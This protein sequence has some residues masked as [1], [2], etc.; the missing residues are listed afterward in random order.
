MVMPDRNNSESEFDNF[1][2][3]DE[4]LL[5]IILRTKELR[6][7]L[8]TNDMDSPHRKDLAKRATMDRTSLP[9]PPP[10]PE[11]GPKTIQNLHRATTIDLPLTPSHSPT[12]PPPAQ[13]ADSDSESI[14]LPTKTPPTKR[15][16]KLQNFM[17]SVSLE[18]IKEKVQKRTSRFRNHFTFDHSADD[19]DKDGEKDRPISA[20]SE[21]DD[22]QWS[23]DSFD[24]DYGEDFE[25]EN[26]NAID[27]A[28]SADS[29]NGKSGE[30]DSVDVSLV[31]APKFGGFSSELE[32]K[33]EQNRKQSE[34]SSNGNDSLTSSPRHNRLPS[35][36][37]ENSFETAERKTEPDDEVKTVTKKG[38]V[39]LRPPGR[40]KAPS[41]PSKPKGHFQRLSALND[42]NKSPPLKSQ[43]SEEGNDNV[44]VTDF[45]KKIKSAKKVN[46]DN[47][48]LMPA[49]ILDKPKIS[50]KP[51][52]SA[53]RPISLLTKP[54]LPPKPKGKASEE[55]SHKPEN[56]V[57]KAKKQSKTSVSGVKP[58]VSPKRVQ[59]DPVG[60]VNI[61]KDIVDLDKV[62]PKPK[63][64]ATSPVRKMNFIS[65]RKGYEH[66][67]YVDLD[68][69]PSKEDMLNSMSDDH[70]YDE[71]YVSTQVPDRSSGDGAEMVD[72]PGHQEGKGVESNRKS[73]GYKPSAEKASPPRAFRKPLIEPND[74]S[75][76]DLYAKPMLLKKKSLSL[77]NQSHIKEDPKSPKE[78]TLKYS[79][80]SEVPLDLSQ[81]SVPDVI[82]CLSL[83][84]MS[85]HADDFQD[86]EID[87]TLL[88]DLDE[89]VLQSEF[90]FSQFDAKKLVKFTNGWRPKLK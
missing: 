75:I 63:P 55:A 87:G 89:A 20:T 49:L 34:S 68:E 23:D 27:I 85:K 70:A 72:V 37:S 43:P 52:V 53:S 2:T 3:K 28:A 18:K 84:K 40:T 16:F 73:P 4:V 58:K 1:K 15:H 78:K 17:P 32:G 44:S 56:P 48:E 65:Q 36:N 50:Q 21:Y 6:L 7:T 74:T 61:S 19:V 66:S 5:R 14:P 31:S 12:P 77:A 62:K 80:L 67:E 88:S 47:E 82:E 13:F 79:S 60:K 51:V 38:K 69:L 83:L 46:S 42:D 10:P 86:N 22:E 26:N 57:I 90:T 76:E 59:K 54:S 45:L 11:G 30:K 24:A 64:R 33:L 81:L 41:L 8:N 71:V 39:A 25:E 35:A 29:V 9:P